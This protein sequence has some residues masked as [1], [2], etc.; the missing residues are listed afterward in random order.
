MNP[1]EDSWESPA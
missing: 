1:A